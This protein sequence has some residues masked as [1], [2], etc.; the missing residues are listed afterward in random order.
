[1][2]YVEPFKH[3]SSIERGKPYLSLSLVGKNGFV[4]WSDGTLNDDRL[5]NA[6]LSPE[7][8]AVLQYIW[9]NNQTDFSK[10]AEMMRGSGGYVSCFPV[11]LA[12]RVHSLVLMHF[13]QALQLMLD[14]GVH[15]SP[16]LWDE[17]CAIHDRILA[18]R[19]SA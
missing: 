16:I 10:K 2:K 3:Y 6:A 9:D 18:A 4:S 7:L 11:H 12:L 13:E 14:C 1:M 8:D 19:V 17:V 5:F 15:S